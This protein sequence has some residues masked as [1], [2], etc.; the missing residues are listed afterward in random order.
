MAT[1]F[2]HS[3]PEIFQKVKVLYEKT[4]YLNKIYLNDD[5]EVEILMDDIRALAGDIYNDRLDIE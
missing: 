2:I 5:R 3:V 1:K 4:E